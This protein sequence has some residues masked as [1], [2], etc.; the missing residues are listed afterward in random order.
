MTIRFKCSHCQKPL[1]VKDHL[2]GKKAAC[3]VC[4][5]VIVI[6]AATQLPPLVDVESMAAEALADKPAEKPAEPVST[7]TIDFTCPFCDEELKLPADLGGKKTPCPKCTNIIKVPLVEAAKPKDWRATHSGGPSAALANLPEQLADAWGTEQKGKVSREAMEEAGA[8]PEPEAAPVGVGVWIRRGFWACLAVGG[9]FFLVSMATR[10]REEKRAQD[11]V[12]AVIPLLPKQ[13]RLH[14]A[15]AFRAIGETYV[16]DLMVEKA[17]DNFAL[18]RSMLQGTPAEGAKDADPPYEHDL[19]LMRLAL[20]QAEMGGSEDEALGG[21]VKQR[22]SWNDGTVLKDVLQTLD[23]MRS[24][25]AKA[26]ALRDLTTAL[27]NKDKT[28]IAFSLIS[29]FANAADGPPGKGGTPFQAQYVGLLL[30]LKKDAAAT[31]QIPAPDLA[32]IADTAPRVAYTEGSARKNDYAQALKFASAKGPPAGRLEACVA[33]AAIALADTGNKDA[34][35]EAKPFIEE[36]FKAY[37]DLPKQIKDK[38]PSWAVL[39]LIRLGSRTDV[40]GIK[41]LV[42][43]LPAEFRPRAQLD[44]F[45]GQLAKNPTKTGDVARLDEIG[46]AKHIV[47]ALA[48]EVLARH[49]SRLGDNG[50]LSAVTGEGNESVRPFVLLGTA[51][52]EQDRR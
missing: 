31:E 26:A 36:G 47:R 39:E 30:A 49:N 44:I 41:E 32:F 19:L 51:L 24:N 45:Q 16:G 43:G 14:Q 28:E 22:F 29:N 46:D 2:A 25:D 33:G 50:T 10:S 12:E 17:R 48:W 13:D 7:K 21:R 6:P 35:R 4:K 40:E 38:A 11:A 52:G 5:K 9:L 3:P 37:K 34:A 1:S 15:E 23:T 27:M 8:L 42:D 20:S 18:A